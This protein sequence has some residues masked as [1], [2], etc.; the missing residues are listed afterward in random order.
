[1]I[2]RQNRARPTLA[3]P[4]RP[5]PA[6]RS[7]E[8]MACRRE[9]VDRFLFHHLTE[10]L[11]C[12]SSQKEKRSDIFAENV[13]FGTEERR[14][15]TRARESRLEHNRGGYFEPGNARCGAR[16]TRRHFVTRA[17]TRRAHRRR[18]THA[19]HASVSGFRL[20]RATRAPARPTLAPH[21]DGIARGGR[22]SFWQNR[23]KA[24][25]WRTTRRGTRPRRTSS[26]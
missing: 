3:S 23:R 13:A 25:R 7:D 21:R 9:S 22:R 18:R 17:E 4:T 26:P 12:R 15:W 1:M 16:E 8:R 14:R 5:L 10:H 6:W 20:S 11:G 19:R 24:P 2:A